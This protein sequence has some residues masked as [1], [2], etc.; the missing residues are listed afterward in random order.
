M[1]NNNGKIRVIVV[2]LEGSNDTLQEALRTVASAIKPV[3][4]IRSTPSLPS[5]SASNGNGSNQLALDIPVDS[6][7]FDEPAELT[8]SSA[9]PK[10]HRPKVATPK[11]MDSID[12][13]G[14]KVPLKEFVQLQSAK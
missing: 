14:G 13:D 7:S 6:E 8:S 1:A 9:K 5:I 3:P 12:F 4:A 2:E 10:K 11:Y